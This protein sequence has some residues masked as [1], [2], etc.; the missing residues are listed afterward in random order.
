MH[1]GVR[2]IMADRLVEHDVT[3]ERVEIRAK[4]GTLLS[5]ERFTVQP[6]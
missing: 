5:E 6:R 3:N 2:L 4:D 1:V